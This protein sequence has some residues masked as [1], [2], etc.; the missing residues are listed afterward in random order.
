MSEPLSPIVSE[1]DTLEQEASHLS[2]LKAKVE[3]SLND[4]R[5]NFAHDQVMAEMHALLD[6]KKKACVTD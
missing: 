2:W 6:A 3:A 1:F 4:T 5:P